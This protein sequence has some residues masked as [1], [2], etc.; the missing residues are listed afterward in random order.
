ML[1][2]LSSVCIRNSSGCVHAIDLY[3]SIKN[4]IYEITLH[5]Q[6]E[7]KRLISLLNQ[8]ME[9]V[10]KRLEVDV[11]RAVLVSYEKEL[12]QRF[13]YYVQQI[14]IAQSNLAHPINPFVWDEPFVNEIETYVG[15]T[16]LSKNIF[17]EE[18]LLRMDQ[19]K[20]KGYPFDYRKH[21]Q[22]REAIENVMFAEVMVKVKR[23]GTF[24]HVG[25]N[26]I[27]DDLDDGESVRQ[28]LEEKETQFMTNIVNHL[29]EHDNYC[30]C[31][32][33]HAIE[34]VQR[35]MKY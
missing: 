5:Q 13:A 23:E 31:C 30:K 9:Q 4:G 19:M 25:N 24:E 34:Y 32:A 20:I 2:Q 14:R 22:L 16:T 27:V 11:R 35:L 18:L 28:R 6:K 7:R 8:A 26:Q 1:N 17:R 12:A 3:E 10:E 33:S 15:I 21:E 29:I